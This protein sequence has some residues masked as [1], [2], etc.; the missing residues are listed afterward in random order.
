M[1]RRTML[2]ILVAA[3][4]ALP[5]A[6]AAAAPAPSASPS[7]TEAPVGDPPA[8]PVG[9]RAVHTTA[10]RTE[11]TWQPAVDDRAVAYRIDRAVG[12]GPA[13][14]YATVD[15]APAVVDGLVAGTFYHFSVSAI[16]AAGRVSRPA[17]LT[18]LT[19]AGTPAPQSCRLSY[20]VFSDWRTGFVAGLSMTN[21]GSVAADDWIVVLRFAGAVQPQQLWNAAV[22]RTFGAD[23]VVLRSAAH[24]PT[25]APGATIGFGLV[26]AA[27]GSEQLLS[28]TVNGVA[29]DLT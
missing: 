28:A 24:N 27:G 12:T 23:H 13:M 17:S 25:L 22:L 5:A 11:L 29:C 6:P 4:S 14:P 10:S 9:L 1:R 7:P 15:A 3:M 16:D 21:T 19:P 18:L 8:A 26:G 2:L 20:T